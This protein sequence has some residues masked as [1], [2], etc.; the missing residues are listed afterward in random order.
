MNRVKK[1]RMKGYE[2][3]REKRR[4]RGREN[5]K[6]RGRKEMRKGARRKPSSDSLQQCNCLRELFPMGTRTCY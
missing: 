2:E 4:E 6:E 3:G 5:W 1:R